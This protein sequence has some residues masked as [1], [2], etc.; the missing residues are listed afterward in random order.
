MCRKAWCGILSSDKKLSLPCCALI[1]I[2]SKGVW[3][4]SVKPLLFSTTKGGL[5]E[6][7]FEQSCRERKIQDQHLS[8][9][10]QSV[11]SVESCMP[12]D[13]PG[14]ISPRPIG[15]WLPPWPRCST[16]RSPS[17]RTRCSP[18]SS[19]R[20]KRTYVWSEVRWHPGHPDMIFV[21]MFTLADFGPIIFY[22]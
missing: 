8:K 22:P 13:M 17:S 1:Q 19:P 3:W 14:P 20:S 9:T 16:R 2:L 12:N 18:P 6:D 21:Q 11:L 10:F 5:S 4:H 15:S 7:F